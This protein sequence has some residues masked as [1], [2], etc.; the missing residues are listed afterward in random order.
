MK[1]AD[2]TGLGCIP[3]LGTWICPYLS[4][5]DSEKQGK[6]LGKEVRVQL[7]KDRRGES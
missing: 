4:H 7:A 6:V 3:L 2:F 1:C 5:K